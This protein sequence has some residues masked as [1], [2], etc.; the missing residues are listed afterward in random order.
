MAREIAEQ[1]A[2]LA[3]TFEHV[4]PL[5]HDITRLAAGRRHVIFVAR[6][7]SDNAGVYG[8]YLTEIH[9]GRQAS[10]AAPS[11]A[12]LYG[13]NLDLSNSLVVAVSQSGATQ[14]I[15]DTAEWAKRNG[16]AIVGITNDGDSPLASTADVALITQAGKELAV[17]AT[18]TYTTQLA[19]ITVAVDAL[20]QRPGTLD[21][22]IARVPDAATKM[23]ENSVEA[24]ADLLAGAHDVLASGRGLTFGT[25]LEVA[26]KLEETCLQPVRGLSYADLKHGPIAVVDADLV[27]ILVAAAEGPALPGM[28]ELA[29]IVREKGSKILGIGG[30]PTFAARC[31][32]NLP[33]PDLPETLTPLALVIPAQRAI[34]SLARKLGLNPDAPRGLRKVTQTD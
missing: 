15:V 20:A 2:A 4:L 12:T 28:I 11:V 21:A 19:A 33:G 32:V 3:A 9:A 1:P 22:D 14:E 34:E 29:G 16:A 8:R 24:A 13:A 23:L 17:P 18:K 30:D 25:T 5:R 27:T 31:D 26:L 6:G 10:L 7:S